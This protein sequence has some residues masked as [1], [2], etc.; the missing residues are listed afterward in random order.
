[1]DKTQMSV[2]GNPD[3]P[4]HRGLCTEQRYTNLINHHTHLTSSIMLKK[5]NLAQHHA[6]Y[7]TKKTIGRAG[8]RYS[9]EP[10]GALMC[11]KGP[12]KEPERN[13]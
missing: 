10:K 9:T 12:G 5:I 3:P 8:N 13:R 1:M 2:T 6:I 11:R 7:R 4:P